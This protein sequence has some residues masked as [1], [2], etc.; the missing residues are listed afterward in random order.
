M[1]AREDPEDPELEAAWRELVAGDLVGLD[2][3]LERWR[4]DDSAPARAPLLI[5]ERHL[6]HGDPSAANAAAQLALKT[7]G[8]DDLDALW[9]AGE[10]ALYGWSIS[11]ADGYFESLESGDPSP[12]VSLKRSLCADLLGD[13]VRAAGHF[14]RARDLDPTTC[15]S[16]VR[17]SPDRFEAAVDTAARA[18]APA[19][20]EAL[21]AFP[22]VLD[23][24]PDFG[25]ARG[26]EAETPPDL[27]GLFV[28][29]TA[30]ERSVEA[31]D[32]FP[33][34]IY[35]FQRNLE[36]AA[37]DASELEEQVRVTLWHELGHALGFEEDGL[38]EL[39]LG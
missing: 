26:R 3:R 16:M 17:W 31:P 8:S 19:F 32:P 6:A 18:L 2:A 13:E 39:G 38:H 10:A 27:L 1:S 36:R 30:L 35:L 21:A 15:G 5:A 23:P 14:E 33:T 34:A 37:A 4:A 25:L 9:I 12:S 29:P 20:A 7:L 22:V 11:A 28:G 24:V